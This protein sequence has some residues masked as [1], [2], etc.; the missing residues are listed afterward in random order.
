MN[1]RRI[2]YTLII[3]CA[4]V[5]ACVDEEL[6]TAN[7][8]EGNMEALWQLLDERYCFFDLK[9]EE[10]GV[11]WDEVHSRYRQ[12]IN[13]NMSTTQLFEVL[14]EMIGELKDGHVNLSASFDLG[15]NWSYWEEYPE[16]YNDSIARSYLG[17]DYRI[18]SS[19]K[20]KVLDDNIGYV[21]CESFDGGMG[22]GNIGDML[23]L[24]AS[25]N[26]LIID[27]R[28][29]GGGQMDNSE[30]LA[31]HFT[32]E[33]VLTGYVYHK[34]GKGR[35]DFSKPKEL[36]LEPAKG[37]RWQKKV[38]VIQNRECFSACNDFIKMMKVLPNVTLLGDKSG[39]GSGLPFTQ[40][41]PNGWA[42]RYSA[43]I[44]LDSEKHHTEF[45]IN[46]DIPV[47]MDQEDVKKKKDTLIERAREFLRN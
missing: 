46:P 29:N 35:N 8:P 42:V 36:W 1:C 39:G 17:K 20:Y 45:G 32:N 6:P 7:T 18:A 4:C 27:V 40:E 38:V 26:G 37:T 12:K 47:E 3:L 30:R 28:G 2:I 9:R 41:L 15:R 11:D 13:G 23:T 34:D 33:K 5:S 22:D 16:N 44:F 25:C 21:R 10:L 14:C 19:L 24:L 43:V 31:S